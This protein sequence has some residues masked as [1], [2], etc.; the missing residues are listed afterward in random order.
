MREWRVPIT[1]LLGG[2][3]GLLATVFLTWNLKVVNY[4]PS[5]YAYLA[6]HWMFAFESLWMFVIC[7]GMSLWESRALRGLMRYW[8]FGKKAYI[9]KSADREGFV[10]RR[11]RA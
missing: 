2:T 6:H 7:L 9:R 1:M 5:G 4:H 3:V 11:K 10:E 8:I